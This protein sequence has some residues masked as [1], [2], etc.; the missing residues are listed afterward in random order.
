V[1]DR[2]TSSAKSWN[3]LAGAD[4]PKAVSLLALAQLLS[5]VEGRWAVE[6]RLAHKAAAT[7]VE[8]EVAQVIDRFFA[9]L[10]ASAK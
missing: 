4:A 7:P 10:R 3:G 2:A 6:L 5:M 1:L 9:K 8:P